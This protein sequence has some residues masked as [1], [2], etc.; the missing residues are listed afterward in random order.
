MS[1]VNN[2]SKDSVMK[3]LGKKRVDE[4]ASN[5]N[6]EEPNSN[7]KEDKDLSHFNESKE[8]EVNNINLKEDESNEIK[9]IIQKD[10]IIVN[11]EPLLENNK[12]DLLNSNLTHDSQ[13]E[14]NT[15]NTENE[16]T[17]LVDDK[18]EKKA[19]ISVI[20][21]N[22]EIIKE[23]IVSVAKNESIKNPEKEDLVSTKEIKENDKLNNRSSDNKEHCSNENKPIIETIVKNEDHDIN[24]K[25]EDTL[26]KPVQQ[27]HEKNPIQQ[28][29]PIQTIQPIQSATKKI[30]L[31]QAKTEIE[32]F[33]L[34]L[35]KVETDLKDKYN[36]VLEDKHKI[37]EKLPEEV[38]LRYIEEFFKQD[39]IKN[40]LNKFN[41]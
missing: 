17:K 19:Q 40:I 4:E 18:E 20:D 1:N 6:N 13:K 35:L 15:N 2:V 38:Q 24:S 23:S 41:K 31:Q 39:S 8:T 26:I 36:I 37:Y 14:A 21:N 27:H 11:E 10:N 3:M 22:N 33:E 32:N 30:T 12:A 9:E 28:V 7:N 29:Q 25:K 5:K 34:Y 16:I